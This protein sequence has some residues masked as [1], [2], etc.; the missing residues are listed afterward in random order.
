MQWVCGMHGTKEQ[1]VRV[2]VGKPK[3]KKLLGV[4]RWKDN[5][6]VYH[7]EIGWGGGRGGMNWI[8]LTLD[9]DS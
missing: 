1:C 5:T 2:L 7:K 6:P 4:P 9:G 3:L 8:H